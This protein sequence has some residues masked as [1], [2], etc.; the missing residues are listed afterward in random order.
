MKLDY[1]TKHIAL[2]QGLMHAELCLQAARK[3]MMIF[4]KVTVLDVTVEQAM[5]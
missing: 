1:D 5:P 4:V 3:Y 2:K